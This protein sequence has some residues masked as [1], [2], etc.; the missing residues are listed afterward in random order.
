MHILNGVSRTG[1]RII[2]LYDLAFVQACSI[3]IILHSELENIE[4]TWQEDKLNYSV[5]ESQSQSPCTLSSSVPVVEMLEVT[6]WKKSDEE[7]SLYKWSEKYADLVYAVL[8]FSNN[9][10]HQ[11]CTQRNSISLC[12]I[13]K[14]LAGSQRHSYWENKLKNSKYNF[15]T[16]WSKKKN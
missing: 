13:N 10:K 14:R 1:I 9:I 8:G 16:S 5:F 6:F 12:C 2:W 11:H 15:V 4:G 3:I 7:T